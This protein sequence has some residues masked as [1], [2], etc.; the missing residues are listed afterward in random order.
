MRFKFST[1]AFPL[2]LIASVVFAVSDSLN[3]PVASLM[4][5]PQRFNN[6]RVT[7]AGYYNSGD[8]HGTSIFSEQ[9]DVSPRIFLNFRNASVPLK[10]LKKI[11]SGAYVRVTG[12]FHYREMKF[13]ARKDVNT[14][15]PGFG[16]MNDYDK[17]ITKI[18]QFNPVAYPGPK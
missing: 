18:T 16:W 10:P 11:P 15:V 12:T 6:K 17:E 2:I 7:F 1:I 14:I 13:Y 8:G 5:H 3:V 4:K 9:S